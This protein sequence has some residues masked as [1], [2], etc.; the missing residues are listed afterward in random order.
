MA[1]TT[2]PRNNIVELFRFI[3][4]LLVLGYHVQFSYS[5][6][7]V[8]FFENGALAVEFYFLLSGY[9]LAR[10]LEKISKDEKTNIIKKVYLFMKNKVNALLNVHILSIIVVTIIILIFDIKKFGKIFLKGI[11]SIFLVHMIVFWSDNF[12]NALIIP[13]WYLSSM[14]ICMLFMV[15][16]Y[17]L[18]SK[19]FK[20]IYITL[21]LVG[22]LAVLTIIIGFVSIWKL[23]ENFVYDL[24]AW[25]EMCVGMFSYY[26]SLYVKNKNYGEK[27]LIFFKILELFGYGLPVI[28]GIIPI[29]LDFQGIL[30][31]ITVICEFCSV[32][33]TFSEKGNILNNQKINNTFG[34]LGTISL[35]IY[36][37]H[38]VLITFI[39]Y[40]KKDLPRW[41][42]YIVVFPFT[43]ILSILY[44]MIANC[45][46]EKKK[47]KEKEEKSK[48][49]QNKEN[50]ITKK[51]E[52]IKENEIKNENENI[53]LENNEKLIENG[54]ED[55]NV[56]VS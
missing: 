4:S 55:E 43:L 3:Y 18:L 5:D 8:D 56:V 32:F 26:L 54:N 38:P 1:K 13:E 10:S 48:E 47:E 39:D 7:K 53:N 20:G 46:N 31:A 14:L 25:G 28:L 17:L 6:D 27:M 12:K 40:I 41:A 50:E 29:S 45:L 52:N 2:K 35:P 44:R 34:F 22:I 15:P 51:D 37:F 9:F 21:F 23:K 36:L 11:P 33:I 30:M 24:R 42:K 49:K 16:I 19:K